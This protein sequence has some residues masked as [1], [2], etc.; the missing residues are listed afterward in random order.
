MSMHEGDVDEVVVVLED[1]CQVDHRLLP[2][3]PFQVQGCLG[4]VNHVYCFSRN[5]LKLVVNP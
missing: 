3:I 2:M 5:V 4:I 1:V